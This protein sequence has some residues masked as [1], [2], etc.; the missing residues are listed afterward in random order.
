MAHVMDFF[1]DLLNEDN[2]TSNPGGSSQLESAVES[3]PVDDTI[4]DEEAAVAKSM[5][6]IV[7]GVLI[8]T[9]VVAGVLIPM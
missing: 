4:I 1:E 3:A 7:T 9:C 5:S 6:G 2:D 8:P